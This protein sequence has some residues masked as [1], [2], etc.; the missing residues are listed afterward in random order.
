[1]VWGK[2]IIAQ[3]PG[4]ELARIDDESLARDKI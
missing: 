2:A 3:I 4:F 1:M